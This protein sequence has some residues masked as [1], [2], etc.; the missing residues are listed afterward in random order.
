MLPGRGSTM[1][2]INVGSDETRRPVLQNRDTSGLAPAERCHGEFVSA[3]AIEVRGF[4]VSHSRPAVQCERDEFSAALASEPDHRTFR[5]IRREE[6]AEVRDEEILD[7]VTIGVG[8]GHVGGVRDVR[9]NGQPTA[10]LVGM[11]GED[12]PLPHV[13]ADHVEPLVAV[14]VDQLQVRYSG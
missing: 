9:D 7:A 14:K 13:G 6:L 3:V 10:R 2:S 12:E 4:H 8:Q 11:A 5:V 1:W